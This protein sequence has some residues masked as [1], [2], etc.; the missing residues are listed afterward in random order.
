MTQEFLA[1]LLTGAGIPMTT[2]DVATLEAGEWP[3]LDLRLLAA[4]TFLLEISLD[5]TLLV[6]FRDSAAAAPEA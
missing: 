5:E 2:E 6:C 1:Y 4:L 3:N